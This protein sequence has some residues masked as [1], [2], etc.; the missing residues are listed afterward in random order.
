MERARDKSN[1]SYHAIPVRLSEKNLNLVK[2]IIDATIHEGFPLAARNT[3]QVLHQLRWLI[4]MREYTP[5]KLIRTLCRASVP[6]ATTS[7][8]SPDWQQCT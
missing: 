1:A 2:T 8:T 5:P 6:T 4:H 7:Q 3:A